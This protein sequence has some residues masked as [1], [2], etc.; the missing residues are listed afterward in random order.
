MYYWMFQNSY[1]NVFASSQSN[2]NLKQN[3]LFKIFCY[4]Y[5]KVNKKETGSI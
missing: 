3:V 5:E 2:L 1:K 4:L